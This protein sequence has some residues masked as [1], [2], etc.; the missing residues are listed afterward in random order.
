MTSSSESRLKYQTFPLRE[1]FSNG[2]HST[3]NRTSNSK[4]NMT[5]LSGWFSDSSFWVPRVLRKP[6][7]TKI[8][9]ISTIAMLIEIVDTM[10]HMAIKLRL[11]CTSIS[12]WSYRPKVLIAVDKFYLGFFYPM[13]SNGHEYYVNKL[14]G[15]FQVYILPKTKPHNPLLDGGSPPLAR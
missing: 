5:I 15:D 13:S 7:S 10:K 11:H 8:W 3:R 1:V 14:D 4:N 12:D 9:N 2:N 6:H